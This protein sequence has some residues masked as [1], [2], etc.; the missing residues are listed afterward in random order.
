M[1]DLEIGSLIAH[2]GDINALLRVKLIALLYLRLPIAR[3]DVLLLD[4]KHH[5]TACQALLDTLR[6]VMALF[7]LLALFRDLL[8]LGS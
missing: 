6:F 8:N 2:Y 3:R 7:V 1:E 5:A 4:G